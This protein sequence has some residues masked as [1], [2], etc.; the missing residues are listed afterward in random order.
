MK[1]R[2]IPPPSPWPQVIEGDL[3]DYES[4]V[5]TFQAN[6]REDLLD[7]AK[8]TSRVLRDQ[9]EN[10][11]KSLKRTKENRVKHVFEFYSKFSMAIACFIFL[12]VGAPMGAIVRKGGFG[13][14]LLISIGFFMLF[15]VITI[16]SKNIAER[17]VIHAVLASWMNCLVVFPMGLVLTYWA[18]RDIGLTQLVDFFK[19][20]LPVLKKNK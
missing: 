6:K 14:P 4:L 2:S 10:L 15:I 1:T 8:G 19:I 17:F 16:F 18:M 9:A 5:A 13:W 11:E 20:K 12:F 3:K 7:R